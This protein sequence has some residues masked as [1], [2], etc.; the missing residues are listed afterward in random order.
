[1]SARGT[2]LLESGVWRSSASC[3]D[4]DPAL[5]FPVGTT[6]AALDQIA[7]ALPGADYIAFGPV[8]ATSNLSRPK[9]VQGLEALRRARAL[10]PP[11]TPLVAIG[12]I[13]AD[14]VDAVREA[15]ADGWAVISAIEKASDP[16][17]AVRALV[18]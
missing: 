2:L 5:F 18:R 11:G 13:T 6:G 9:P 1:M 17:A 3:Q 10:V 15:G 12:G 16:E 14:R 7:A 8:F 4:T